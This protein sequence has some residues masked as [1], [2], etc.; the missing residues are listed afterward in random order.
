[1][2]KLLI[3]F[4]WISSITAFAQD[5]LLNDLEGN[6]EEDKKVVLSPKKGSLVFLHGQCWH[7]VLPV[8]GDYRVSTNYRCAPK[9][10]PEN[11]TDIGIYRN[12]RYQFSTEQV[13]EERT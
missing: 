3:I 9:G 2:R 10:T 13:L 7:G 4:L 11:I 5:D 1:M 8:T 12:I 6:F